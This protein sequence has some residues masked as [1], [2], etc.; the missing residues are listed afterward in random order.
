MADSK[1]SERN[2]TRLIAFS[3][4]KGGSGK[5]TTSVNIAAALSY[6]GHDVLLV[7][8]DPQAHST[9]SLGVSRNGTG[10]DLYS[11]LVN[12]HTPAEAVVA[13]Q[14]P[15]LSVLPASRKLSLY[16][17]AYT[18]TKEARTFMAA[19]T[20]SV[21][22]SFDFVVFDTPP[23]L[24]LM[25]I[26]ALIACREVYVPMQTHFLALEGLAEMIRLTRQIDKLYGTGI[27][28][29]G[30]IPTFYRERTRL[31][32][33]IMHE[34]R[35]NLGEDILLHPVR[36]SVALAEA[37]SHGKSI[38]QYNPRSNGAHDYNAIARQIEGRK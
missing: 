13:T 38:F 29:E 17:R 3:N 28:I 12:G 1:H 9:L 19:K 33:S 34:I 8:T 30:I 18:K 36:I 23:T 31:A 2:G 25:T 22:G 6:L 20:N 27:K 35:K 5:T 7:D 26:S 11:V 15:R 10:P 24:S 21:F 16:E 4:R 37:P 32:R 14:I